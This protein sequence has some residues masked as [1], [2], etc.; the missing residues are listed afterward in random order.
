[1]SGVPKKKAQYLIVRRVPVEATRRAGGPIAKSCS[2]R[3]TILMNVMSS[4]RMRWIV[5]SV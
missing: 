2:M 5:V 4:E 3:T 1:L